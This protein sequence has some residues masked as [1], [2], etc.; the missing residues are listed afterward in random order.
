MTKVGMDHNKEPLG[1]GKLPAVYILVST[2]GLRKLSTNLPGCFLREKYMASAEEVYRETQARLHRI[3]G[4][5]L[6]LLAW[7]E[8]VD[9]VV[10]ERDSLLKFLELERM[11]NARIDWLK[12]DL[13]YLFKYA[14][15]TNYTKNGNYATLYLSRVLIP[16]NDGIWNS[17]DTESRIKKLTEK[18]IKTKLIEM[19]KEKDL[20]VKMALISNGVEK[21]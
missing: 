10:I 7:K 1:S 2:V 15:T 6:S 16:N 3:L 9:C 18:G 19:P 11:R 8:G 21:I 12:E 20:L 14:H 17:M 5:Y 4:A 13:K